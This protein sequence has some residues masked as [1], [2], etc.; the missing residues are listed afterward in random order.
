MEILERRNGESSREWVK[1]VLTENIV[2]LN[3]LPGAPLSDK[4]I[5]SSLSLSRTPVREALVLLEEMGFVDVYPQKGTFV[6]LLNIDDIEEGR[7]IRKCLEADTL[8]QACR[9]FSSDGEIR[10]EANLKMQK[11]AIAS[12]DRKRFLFLD[13]DFHRILCEGCGRARVWSVI[14]KNSLHFFRVRRLKVSKGAPG[15]E[16]YYG[17]HEEILEAIRAQDADRA[18]D[19]LNRHLSWDVEVVREAYP[20]FFTSESR[21]KKMYMFTTELA[22]ADAGYRAEHLI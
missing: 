4:E 14:S 20:E 8:I 6:S 12:L 18:L 3:L 15:Q 17:Q 1:R 21:S 13:Q 19:I 5:A 9:S 10:L 22:P 16:F 7:Y 2:H 11:N